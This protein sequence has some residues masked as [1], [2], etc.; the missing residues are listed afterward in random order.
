[1]LFLRYVAPYFVKIYFLWVSSSYL[2]P[3]IM[4]HESRI[5]V[6]SSLFLHTVSDTG[7]Y[8]YW[9]FNTWWLKTNDTT[10]TKQWVINNSF[11]S[12]ERQ[13][14]SSWTCSHAGLE[15]EINVGLFLLCLFLSQSKHLIYHADALCTDGTL[16]CIQ[17]SEGN[18]F[19]LNFALETSREFRTGFL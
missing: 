19:C 10:M 6:S 17:V 3:Y 16:S 2:S 14:F 7:P 13:I 15:I 9:V 1:M 5:F 4:P 8:W 12:Y 11:L 18:N